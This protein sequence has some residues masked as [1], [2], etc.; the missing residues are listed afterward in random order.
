[1]ETDSLDN[2]DPPTEIDLDSDDY[3]V[4]GRKRIVDDSLE[5]PR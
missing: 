5:N 4:A 2:V 1:M 3:V